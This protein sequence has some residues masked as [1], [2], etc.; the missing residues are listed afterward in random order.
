MK[1]EIEADWSAEVTSLMYLCQAVASGKADLSCITANITY[2]N[3]MAKLKKL[4][5]YIVPGVLGKKKNRREPEGLR[6]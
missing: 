3:G 2:L 6:P 4:E 1:I 5:G